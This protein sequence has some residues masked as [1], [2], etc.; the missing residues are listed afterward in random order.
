MNVLIKL[1]I[2]YCRLYSVLQSVLQFLS[3]L[4]ITI[5]LYLR[6][7]F[8]RQLSSSFINA[9]YWICNIVQVL[10]LTVYVQGYPFYAWEGKVKKKL[11]WRQKC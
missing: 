4:V 9:K 7:N 2:F 3:N 6:F 11:R 5:V 8:F 1:L 10:V